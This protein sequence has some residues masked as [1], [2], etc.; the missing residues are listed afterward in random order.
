M[1]TQRKASLNGERPD[2]DHDGAGVSAVAGGEMFLTAEEIKQLTRRDRASAQK[3]MLARMGIPFIPHPDG[4]FAVLRS[5]VD[6]AAVQGAA[7]E[8]EPD[9]NAAAQAK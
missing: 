3:R 1:N 9:W 6:P 4:G 8:W 5:A 7:K 2:F